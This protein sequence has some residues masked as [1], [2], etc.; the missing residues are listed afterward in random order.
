MGAL[1]GARR[2]SMALIGE[3]E[4]DG[5]VRPAASG[6]SNL[7]RHGPGPCIDPHRQ[8]LPAGQMIVPPAVDQLLE[9][10]QMVATTTQG[11]RG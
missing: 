4:E 1:R 2:D 11:A 7:V 10:L 8:P 5:E 9:R 6:F 3:E